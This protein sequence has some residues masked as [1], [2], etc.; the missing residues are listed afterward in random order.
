MNHSHSI[1]FLELL[2][3]HGP[4]CQIYSGSNHQNEHTIVFSLPIIVTSTI[5]QSISKCKV[6]FVLATVTSCF[7]CMLRIGGWTKT[8]SSCICTLLKIT[9]SENRKRPKD[10]FS[11]CSYQFALLFLSIL[12]TWICN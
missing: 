8:G 10:V 12:Y 7:V 9:N 5:S 1:F 2:H 11:K 4:S 3:L 6:L